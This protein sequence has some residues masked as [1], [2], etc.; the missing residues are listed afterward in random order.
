MRAEAADF[1]RRRSDIMMSYLESEIVKFQ[2]RW[3]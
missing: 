2:K 1:C 3:Y